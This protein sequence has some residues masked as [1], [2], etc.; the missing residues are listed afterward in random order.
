MNSN[1][2]QVNLSGKSKKRTGLY[3]G[4][5][6]VDIDKDKPSR[7]SRAG[8][9]SASGSAV[10][11]EAARAA[12]YQALLA[13]QQAA[14]QSSYQ[15]SLAALNATYAQRA[16][17]MQAGYQDTLAQLQRQYESGASQ[18]NAQDREFAA[19]GLPQL[20]ARAAGPAPAAGGAGDQ[21]RRVGEPARR[22]EEQLR[23]H[24]GPARAGA[25]GRALGAAEH[26]QRG[27]EQRPLQATAAPSRRT[28]RGG[29]PTSWSWS[30]TSPASW[31]RSSLRPSD[32]MPGRAHRLRAAGRREKPPVWRE[33][34]RPGG[35]NRRRPPCFG[36][37]PAE[38]RIGR[39][40]RGP[41]GIAPGPRLFLWSGYSPAR[42]RN[43][44]R[45]RRPRP[46]L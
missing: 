31:R 39:R 27:Q 30:R 15:R 25:G 34:Q 6:E 38:E 35:K 4:L 10:S 41:G 33:K 22:A 43:S 23:Q 24:P 1:S 3:S 17:Q 32:R 36:G 5:V 19:A 2:N 28:R 13:Q 37:G 40:G 26:P 20:Y 18:L 9:S 21:R 14:A 12:A 29:W 11:S 45:A 16:Q 7:S 8:S 46:R 42:A 44:P